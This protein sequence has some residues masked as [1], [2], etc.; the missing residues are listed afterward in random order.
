MTQRVAVPLLSLFRFAN[1]LNKRQETRMFMVFFA[2]LTI[3]IANDKM[4]NENLATSFTSS[5][6]QVLLPAIQEASLLLD[7]VSKSFYYTNLGNDNIRYHYFINSNGFINYKQ[8][9]QAVL[10]T[11]YVHMSYV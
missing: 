11:T 10:F 6:P 7:A 2:A 4:F 5:L 9:H 3:L 1:L 8:Y